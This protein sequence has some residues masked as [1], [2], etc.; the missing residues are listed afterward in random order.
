MEESRVSDGLKIAAVGGVLGVTALVAYW[1]YEPAGSSTR[2]ASGVSSIG[3]D[4]SSAFQ[5]VTS[6]VESAL[7]PPSRSAPPV[8]SA[9]RHATAPA[10][11]VNAATSPATGAPSPTLNMNQLLQALGSVLGGAASTLG[12]SVPA[13]PGSHA[14]PASH[15]ASSPSSPSGGAPAA[16]AGRSH[17]ASAPQAAPKS[18]GGGKKHH[19]TSASSPS[20]NLSENKGPAQ[21]VPSSS[22][23][24]ALGSTT[25]ITQVVAQVD[26]TQPSDSSSSSSSTS[27]ASDSSGENE[28]SEAVAGSDHSDALSDLLNL[29]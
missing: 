9:P 15:A 20:G 12:V 11:A 19:G 7:A 17:T 6:T 28:S 29:F 16:H 5:D 8:S 13:T 18:Q 24:T 1:F 3:S 10:A 23:T 26:D 2:R 21:P 27:A 22:N 25:D 4:L 14:A